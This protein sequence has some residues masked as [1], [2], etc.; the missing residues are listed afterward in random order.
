M[1]MLDVIF[2]DNSKKNHIIYNL[3]FSAEDLLRSE[4]LFTNLELTDKATMDKLYKKT[5]HC[6]QAEHD[7][8]TA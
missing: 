2:Q 7:K 4:I 3:T 5:N 6:V 8:D 1:K